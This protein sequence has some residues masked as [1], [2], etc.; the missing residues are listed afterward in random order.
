MAAN[1]VSPMANAE[2]DIFY[3]PPNPGDSYA[4][5]LMASGTAG[6]NGST[7][8]VLD[9]SM[10]TD[11]GDLGDGLDD[12]FNVLIVATDAGG[13]VTHN[14]QVVEEGSAFSGTEIADPNAVMT[15]NEPVGGGTPTA[16]LNGTVVATAYS[17]AP[18]LADNSAAGM[19]SVFNYTHNGSTYRQTSITAVYSDSGLSPWSY[20]GMELEQSDRGFSKTW[21]NTG[22]YH[23]VVWANY[24]HKKYKYTSCGRWCVTWYQWDPASW[25]GDI[26]DDN[27]NP[28][29]Q[30]CGATGEVSYTV[31][32]FTKNRNYTTP[33]T[34]QSPSVT[35]SSDRIE[36]Y[37]YSFSFAGFVSAS[38]QSTYGSI[39]SVTWDYVSSGC[40]SDR[41]LWGNGY[42]PSQA[43]IEQANCFT[44]PS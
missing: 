11:P 1:G 15:P 29:C 30:G 39:T 20:D 35:R 22:T 34:A 18:V 9:T 44:R 23:D 17:Y 36:T 3:L 28:A 27:P 31:P 10:V 2:V 33:L 40:T 4:G 12:A 8:L 19:Q 43:P 6:A 16:T 21:S 7:T 25:T 13:D 14:V 26:T 42:A 5:Q 37:G 32:P 24:E 41:L 38:A